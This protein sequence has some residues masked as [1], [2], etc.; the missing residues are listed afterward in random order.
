[1]LHRHPPYVH[2]RS[3]AFRAVEWLSVLYV[4]RG[5]TGVYSSSFPQHSTVTALCV[6]AVQWYVAAKVSLNLA[7][8]ISITTQHALYRLYVVIRTW[9]NAILMNALGPDATPGTVLL[10]PVLP[11]DIGA[12]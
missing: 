12:E 4:V 3:S 5:A 2:Q 7:L 6:A 10:E 1:M 9:A 11:F 8:G